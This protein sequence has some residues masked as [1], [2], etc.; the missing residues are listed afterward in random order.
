MGKFP[1]PVG[2]QLGQKA[3]YGALYMALSL[4]GLVCL[5]RL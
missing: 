1:V 2:A 4:A 3:Q 5:M